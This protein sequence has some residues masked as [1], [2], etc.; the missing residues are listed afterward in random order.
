MGDQIQR[1]LAELIRDEVR[2]P[3]VGM[4]TVSGVD[5]TRDLAHAK[6]YVTPL[7]GNREE[8]V[9]LA[10]ALN[11]ASSFL[12]KL[13][14]Q[15]LRLRTVPALKF[16]YD[17]SFERGARLSALIDQ[18]VGERSSDAAGEDESNQDK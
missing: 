11:H 1:E 12:R 2:D 6:V 7:G 15:R 13:L 10:E 5:V 16:V 4:V 3:R 8:G 14:G 9:E 18:A 17:E